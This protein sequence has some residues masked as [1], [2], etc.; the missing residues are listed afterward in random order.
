MA[1][2][3]TKAVIVTGATSFIASGLLRELVKQKRSVYAICRKDSARQYR[4]PESPQIT[5]VECDLSELHLLKSYIPQPCSVFYH[6]GWEGTG[7]KNNMYLQNLNVKYTLDA[8]DAAAALG[9]ETFIGAGSQAE[10]GLVDGKLT[11]NTPTFPVNGYGMAKLCAGQ[12]SRKLCNDRGIKHIWP[13]ILSIYGPMDAETTMI[14]STIDALLKNE[15]PKLT[16]G[17]QIWDFMYIDDCAR[18]LYL[19]SQ[20]GKDGKIYPVGS[21]DAR[22]LARYIEALKDC[23]GTSMMLQYGQVPYNRES[24]MRLEADLDQLKADT[25]FEP[26]V[27]FDEGIKNTIQWKRMQMNI[28]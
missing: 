19:L 28:G 20:Y 6:L 26:A 25:G 17:K 27:S 8:V 4:V 21:G 5:K 23:T 7:D 3:N 18:A 14:M 1:V 12:M 11:G 10:Y 15:I 9:C 24:I 16:K 2:D 13:R 22:P